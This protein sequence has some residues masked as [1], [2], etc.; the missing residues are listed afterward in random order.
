M[1]AKVLIKERNY[2]E[3]TKRLL[4]AVEL[5]KNESYNAFVVFSLYSDLEYCYK[6]LY[7]YEKAYLYSSKRM[8]LLES[9]KN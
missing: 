3:A 4:N 6:Q 2:L 9:F 1:E 8:T 7:N 5:S